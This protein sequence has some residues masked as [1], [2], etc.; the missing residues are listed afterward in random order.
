MT[1][2]VCVTCGKA[3]QR[4]TVGAIEHVNLS[5]LTQ[6]CVDCLIGITKEITE[7]ERSQPSMEF[8]ARAAA[9]RNDA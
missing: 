8:D 6:Q 9:A 2:R 7:A 4:W 5:P 1:E 3:E